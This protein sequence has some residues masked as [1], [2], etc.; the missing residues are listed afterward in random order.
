M[1]IVA[2]Y[3]LTVTLK[4]GERVLVE[5]IATRERLWI[6]LSGLRA[7]TGRVSIHAPAN[8]SIVREELLTKADDVQ[9]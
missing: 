9:A 1:W 5:N 7:H 6:T 4:Q 2:K 8:Y 3:G